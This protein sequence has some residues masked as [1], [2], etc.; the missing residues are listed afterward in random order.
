MNDITFVILQ[1][2]REQCPIAW[3][4]N[5]QV[6]IAGLKTGDYSIKGLEDH[7]AI[8]RKN[9]ID[10][11]AMCFGCARERFQAELLRLRSY[12]CKAV[13][14]QGSLR[15]ILDHNYRNRMEPASIIG[16]MASWQ[17]RY[18]VPFNLCDDAEG[19][20]TMALALMRNYYRQCQEF[21]KVFNLSTSAGST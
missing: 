8:E 6:E 21:A 3:T 7:V 18:G 10:E 20:S 11:L 17:L 1:D 4:S 15:Q 5:V 16:T 2:S 12:R 9:G 19:V 14:I 13:L